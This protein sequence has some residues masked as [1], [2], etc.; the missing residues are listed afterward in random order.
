MEKKRWCLI[1]MALCLALVF[2]VSSV[3]AQ[4]CVAGGAMFDWDEISNPRCDRDGDCYVRN[5]NRCISDNPPVFPDFE[6]NVDCD[7]SD[8]LVIGP[9]PCDEP[10]PEPDP[11]GS[12]IIAVVA[13]KF[14]GGGATGHITSQLLNGIYTNVRV[15]QFNNWEADELYA[16]FNGLHIQWSSPSSM[17]VSWKKLEDFMLLGGFILFEDPQNVLEINELDGVW[18]EHHVPGDDPAV[19]EFE[20]STG[21][22]ACEEGGAN[23]GAAGWC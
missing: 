20:P 8:P 4:Q 23:E 10:E 9:P 3:E 14:G 15:N 2:S 13:N 22:L 21:T 7:D 19:V 11:A 12:P 17:Q 5:N 18:V 1:L 16:K 6:D